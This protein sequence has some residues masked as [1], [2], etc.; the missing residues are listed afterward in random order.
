MGC[1]TSMQTNKDIIDTLL[2]ISGYQGD[3]EFVLEQSLEYYI[4]ID[5]VS[6]V[7]ILMSDENIRITAKAI[8]SAMVNGLLQFIAYHKNFKCNL[9]HFHLEFAVLTR[10]STYVELILMN[11]V[12]PTNTII[13]YIS[14]RPIAQKGLQKIV[15]LLIDYGL[16]DSKLPTTYTKQYNNKRMVAFLLGSHR[17][18]SN[19]KFFHSTF[20]EYHLLPIIN[21]FLHT[22]NQQLYIPGRV[23]DFDYAYQ[24]LK[25]RYQL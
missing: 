9:T 19:C 25:N 2:H 8:M 3:R 20:A 23:I 5:D 16:D 14:A 21:R 1:G 4:K 17:R 6:R 24:S 7:R 10:S 18:L 22:D 15:D 12:K 11:G 13:Q